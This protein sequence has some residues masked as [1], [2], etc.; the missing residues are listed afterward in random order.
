M[1]KI[2]FV[3]S[4]GSQLAQFSFLILLCGVYLG[5]GMQGVWGQE[6]WGHLKGKIV[7]SGDAP[8][9]AELDLGTNPDREYCLVDGRNPV[10]KNLKVSGK[11]EL[12]DVL[13][14][15]Y[16]ASGEEEP[17]YHPSY[18]ATKEIPAELDNK[19]CCFVPQTLFVRTGQKLLLKNSDTIGH[20]CHIIAFNN[21]HNVNIPAG[22]K[23][24]ITMEN[25]ERAPGEVKC[26]IHP[27]MSSV[28]MVRDNPYVAFS[29]ADGQFTIENIPAGNWKFQFWHK[30]VGWMRTLEIE[31][32][33]VGR[34][35]EIE[36]EI[37]AGDTLDLNQLLLPADSVK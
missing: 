34:R 2:K 14:M 15:M 5:V 22:S 23:V 29:D 36:V 26:D 18:E 19:E 12:A 31:G 3:F 11:N 4:Q 28:I 10:D 16:L 9:P 20:N 32:Y 25:P 24:E 8:K 30:K 17:S 21:E 6:P 1:I 27:W 37:K 13:V 35:G 33:E 7:I